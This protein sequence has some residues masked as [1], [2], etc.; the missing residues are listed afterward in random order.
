M[1]RFS[2]AIVLLLA[3]ALLRAQQPQDSLAAPDSQV[4]PKPRT[5]ARYGFS[6]GAVAIDVRPGQI[7]AIAAAQ[8]D[9]AATITLRA[10]DARAWTDSTRRFVTRAAPR[11]STQIVLQRS[12]AAEASDSGAAIS[13]LRRA[14]SDTTTF[15][16]LF[17]NRSF[18]K[19]PLALERREAAMFFAAMRR[20]V[21]ATRPPAPPKPAT[22]AK[23]KPKVKKD[24]TTT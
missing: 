13:F 10:R 11:K 24:S 6:D 21:D 5:I 3:P 12:M 15:E 1:S 16:L 8:G 14:A 4:A 18:G 22:K 20:A 7:I 2:I 23:A 19:F 9:S 17:S